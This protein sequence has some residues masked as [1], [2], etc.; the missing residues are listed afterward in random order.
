M[1]FEYKAGE[2][3]HPSEYGGSPF[4]AL[5]AEVGD[6]VKQ[7]RRHSLRRFAGMDADEPES[8]GERGM[9]GAEEAGEYGQ[10]ACPGCEAGNC[11]NPEHMDEEGKKKLLVLLA[12]SGE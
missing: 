5:L 2:R 9:D 12:P 10:D 7:H 8:P 1:P 6:F 4:K 3:K 11:D